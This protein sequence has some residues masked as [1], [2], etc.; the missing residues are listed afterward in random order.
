MA[1]DV[2]LPE[3]WLGLQS[4]SLGEHQPWGCL[5]YISVTLPDPKAGYQAFMSHN[6]NLVDQTSLNRY[7]QQEEF[8]MSH[9]FYI[10]IQS[11]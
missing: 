3:K 11:S 4:I 1:D 9:E 8:Y 5:R 10:L 7:R 2:W 6:Q